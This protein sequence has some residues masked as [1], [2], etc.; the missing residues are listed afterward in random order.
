MTFLEDCFLI[1]NT[2]DNLFGLLYLQI[3]EKQE[4]GD[5]LRC[6]LATHRFHHHEEIDN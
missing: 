5:H 2:E 4:M 3:C 1:L 6:L